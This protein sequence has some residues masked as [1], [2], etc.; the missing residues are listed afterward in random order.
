MAKDLIALAGDLTAERKRLSESLRRL[1][2]AFLHGDVAKAMFKILGAQNSEAMLAEL[3]SFARGLDRV[4]ALAKTLAQAVSQERLTSC[5]PLLA[6]AVS[7][8]EKA[9]IAS[10]RHVVTECKPSDAHVD[11]DLLAAFKP[12]FLEML[13]S[14]VEYCVEP[15]K[16]RQARKKSPRAHFQIEIRPLEAGYR[17]M[18]IC[19]GNGIIPPLVGAHGVKLARVGVRASFEGKPGKWSVWRFHVPSGVGAFH[20]LPVRTGARRLCIPSWSILS[21]E[22]LKASGLVP[23]RAWSVD[24]QL[25]RVEKNIDATGRAPGGYLVAV[26]AGTAVVTYHFEGVQEPEE[27]F[28]KPLETAFTANGRI[29]GVV[30]SESAPNDELCLVL[31]P[32]YLVYGAKGGS[33]AL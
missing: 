31:N 22:P 23:R 21:I 19:D 12:V 30:A 16:E 6:E 3:E 1:E 27:S 20:C 28:M 24:D 17:I 26:A 7:R 14:M 4:G 32:A 13:D 9:A 25:D 33:D 18:I 11:R 15:I 29:M 5:N 8:I 10:E 2:G